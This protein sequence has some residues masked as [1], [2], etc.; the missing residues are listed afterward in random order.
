MHER[1]NSVNE[2]NRIERQIR[3]TKQGAPE[4]ISH[5]KKV[6]GTWVAQWWSSQPHIY[7]TLWARVRVPRVRFPCV[8]FPHVSSHF[9][10]VYTAHK[11]NVANEKKK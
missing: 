6:W 9:L 11:A 5:Q 10:S 2:E 1:V 4:R 3:H 7:A 8:S